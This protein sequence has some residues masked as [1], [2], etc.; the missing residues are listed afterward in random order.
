MGEPIKFSIVYVSVLK[1]IEKVMSKNESS[2]I[3][4]SGMEGLWVIFFLFF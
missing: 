3:Y 1:Q 2:L 4:C